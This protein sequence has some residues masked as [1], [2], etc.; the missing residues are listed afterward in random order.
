MRRSACWRRFATAELRLDRTV[1]V[2][3]TNVREKRHMMGLLVP[4][5]HTLKHLLRQNRQDFAVA[6]N[7]H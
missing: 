5:L 6:I 2:S 1:E 4:N 3:V 7:R